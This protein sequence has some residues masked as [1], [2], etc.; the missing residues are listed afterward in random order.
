MLDEGRETWIFNLKSSSECKIF[1][2]VKKKTKNTLGEKEP[3]AWKKTIFFAR[4]FLRSR[5]QIEPNARMFVGQQQKCRNQAGG[6]LSNVKHSN[7]L[8]LRIDPLGCR[9]SILNNDNSSIGK[10]DEEYLRHC[11]GA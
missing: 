7:M 9:L 5:V 11:I 4:C 10:S 2:F 8:T 6:K 3:K 1:V